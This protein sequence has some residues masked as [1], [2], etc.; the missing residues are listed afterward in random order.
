MIIDTRIYSDSC[1]SKALYSLA[2][3]YII[4]RR[5]VSDNEEE[6]IV[7]DMKS[8]P[9]NIIRE[10]I[11]SHLND[12]KLRDIIEKETHDIRTILYAKAFSECDYIEE[13]DLDDNH[14]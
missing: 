1:I 2:D 12:Y 5:Y 10:E 8:L 14:V 4:E 3:K 11:I 9:E 6:L 7:S 13:R